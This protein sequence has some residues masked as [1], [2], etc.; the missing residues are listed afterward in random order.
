MKTWLS[1]ST[2]SLAIISIVA[3]SAPCYAETPTPKTITPPIV[4]GAAQQPA[5]S[6]ATAQP[7]APNETVGVPIA[8]PVVE[9][10][11]LKDIV[12][13]KRPE[14]FATAQRLALQNRDERSVMIQKSIVCVQQATTMEELTGCQTDERKTLDKIRLSYCDTMV[15]FFNSKQFMPKRN[16]DNKANNKQNADSAK[17]GLDDTNDDNVGN[18]A[19]VKPTKQKATECDKALAAVTGKPVPRRNSVQEQEAPQ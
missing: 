15:S 2:L 7:V 19:Q 16:K 13:H 12:I 18:D 14:D 10:D 11:P 1:Y 3:I 4:D 17:A 9:D 6:A 5:A 8:I